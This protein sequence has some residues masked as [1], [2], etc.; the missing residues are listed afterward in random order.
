MDLSRDRVRL[1]TQGQTLEML[2]TLEE[3]RGQLPVAL[4]IL[5]T[6]FWDTSR[7]LIYW[8]SDLE[9]GLR[10]EGAQR[11]KRHGEYLADLYERIVKFEIGFSSNIH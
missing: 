7:R 2:A 5:K 4:E 1:G 10:T 8:G 9:E 6:S 3:E 11:L